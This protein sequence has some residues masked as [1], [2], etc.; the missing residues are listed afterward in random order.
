V[1]EKEQGKAECPEVLAGAGAAAQR[2]PRSSRRRKSGM[3]RQVRRRSYEAKA[4][5]GRDELGGDAVQ[6]GTMS[7]LHPCG[8]RGRSNAARVQHAVQDRWRW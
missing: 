8:G 3:V 1:G 5:V 6:P 4:T 7:S 2:G